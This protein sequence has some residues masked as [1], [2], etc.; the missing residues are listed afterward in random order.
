VD[1]EKNYIL[2]L[3]QD[4][5]I[6]TSD[7]LNKIVLYSKDNRKIQD[8][9]EC[10]DST[11]SKNILSINEIANNLIYIVYNK[12]EGNKEEN[13]RGRCSMPLDL[14]EKSLDLGELGLTQ[15]DQ[16]MVIDLGT[17]IIE[18]S[19]DKIKREYSLPNK[20]EILGVLSNSMILI[21]EDSQ[22]FLFE[23]NTFKII[24]KYSLEL[25]GIPIYLG[26]LTRRVNLYDF[27]IL[28]EKLNIFQN[29]Y[30]EESQTIIQISGLKIKNKVENIT[31]I[32]KIIQ[33]PFKNI[34]SYIGDN[35]FIVINY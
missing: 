2:C 22:V 5:Y 21:R 30:D 16:P 7:V 33:N 9:S 18:L 14:T 17:K 31:K 25:G 35:K 29:I 11:H 6:I 19:R 4:D 27:F 20:Q 1:E 13:I 28:D 26:F 8:I 23:A 3:E 12:A 32:R 15:L 10:I 34:Y 24:K